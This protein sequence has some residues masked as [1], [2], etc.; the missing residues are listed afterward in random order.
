MPAPFDTLSAAAAWYE[1]WLVEAA[2]PLWAS[3]G[4]DPLGGLFQETLSL[5]GQP[6]EA[7]RHPGDPGAGALAAQ[8]ERM[9]AALVD[10]RA[11]GG[12]FRENGPHPY[13]ANCHMHLLESALAWEASGEPVWTALS[14]EIVGLA[15]SRF[16]DP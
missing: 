11:P 10:R 1:A 7:P 14:N 12:G 16:I 4:V 9:L 2:L 5:E 3:A 8:A 13:Q 15:L 6:V